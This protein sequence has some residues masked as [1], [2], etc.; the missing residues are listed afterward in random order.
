MVEVFY[1]VYR[2]FRIYFSI[3]N[4]VWLSFH[5]LQHTFFADFYL[6]QLSHSRVENMYVMPN[7]FGVEQRKEPCKSDTSVVFRQLAGH[8]TLA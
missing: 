1:K 6:G 3:F 7:I 4:V 5:T 2:I 8:K